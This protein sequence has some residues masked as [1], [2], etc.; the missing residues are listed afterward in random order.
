L[1]SPT[2]A[3]SP[4]GDCLP[5]LLSAD[6]NERSSLA[7]ETNLGA[8][9]TINLEF[10]V[11]PERTYGLVVGSRQALLP[12]YLLYQALA[13]MGNNAGYWLAEIERKNITG[14]QR[15][16]EGLIGGIE[17]LTANSA[18]TWQSIGEI[19]EHGLLAVDI[20]MIPLGNISDTTI[21]V[22]LQVTKGA[23]RLDY[24]AIAELSAPLQPIRLYPHTILRNGKED[25][26]ARTSL[27]DSTRTLVTLPGDTYTLKYTL[28]RSE[29]EYELF[30]ESR[31]YYLEWIRKEWIEE[32]NPFFLAQM[33][34]D[35]EN[36]L[37]R[38]APEFKR[39][40]PSME[41]CFWRSQYAKP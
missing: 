13:Y 18:G 17:I 10:R 15:A 36:A 6:W 28:P 27:L 37:K 11:V 2:Y 22:Q 9:E 16:I 7:D 35:P 19:N 12:T 8:K 32:Q 39:V 30:L 4:E 3:R 33:F 5:A 41:D 40:E 29:P 25:N 26:I 20:H 38:L 23:W 14:K 21:N 34:L 24:A 31:G 1:I